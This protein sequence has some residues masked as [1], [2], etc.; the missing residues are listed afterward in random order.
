MNHAFSTLYT[1][2]LHEKLQIRLSSIIQNSITFKNGNRKKKY[3]CE[4]TLWLQK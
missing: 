2:I 1:A 3:F 4:G